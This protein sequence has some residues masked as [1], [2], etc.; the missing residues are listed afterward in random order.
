MSEKDNILRFEERAEAT[1]E[2]LF[3]HGLNGHHVKTWALDGKE[4]NYWPKWIEADV[5]DSLSLSFGYPAPLSIL[6]S[7]DMALPDRARNALQY[8]VNKRT[9]NRPVIVVVHSM[10]GLLIKQMLRVAADSNNARFKAWASNIAGIIFFATPH[11][12]SDW[13]SILANFQLASDT[14]AQMRRSSSWLEELHLWFVERKGYLAKAVFYETQDMLGVTKIVQTHSAIFDLPDG[15]VALDANHESITKF[16]GRDATGYAQVC[17]LV[18]AAARAP[19]LLQWPGQINRMRAL[20]TGLASE[21][22]LAGHVS[23]ETEARLSEG[24]FI[25]REVGVTAA[26]WILKATQAP[27]DTTRDADGAACLISGEAGYGKT[28][29]LWWLYRRFERDGSFLTIFLS[30]SWLIRTGSATTVTRDD[31]LAFCTYAVEIG[32]TP[33]ILIDTVDLLLRSDSDAA[34]VINALLEETCGAG[35]RVVMTTRPQ[36]AARLRATNYILTRS[37][38]DGYS[39]RERTAALGAYAARFYPSPKIA[40]ALPNF[41]NLQKELAYAG[42]LTEVCSSPLAMRMLFEIYAPETIPLQIDMFQLY[43]QYWSDRVESDRRSLDGQSGGNDLRAATQLIALLMLSEGQL[44]LE[45]TFLTEQLHAKNLRSVAIGE[46]VHRGILVR[47]GD[48]AYAFFHQTFFEHA[49]SRAMLDLYQAEGIRMLRERS[50]SRGGDLFIRPILEHALLLADRLGSAFRV[51]VSE[52]FHNLLNTKQLHNEMTAIGVFCR[53]RQQDMTRFSKMQNWIRSED[54]KPVHVAELMRHAVNLPQQRTGELFHLLPD[55]WMVAEGAL[56][57]RLHILG[58]LPRFAWRNASEVASF[59]ETHQVLNY[60]FHEDQIRSKAATLFMEAVANIWLNGGDDGQTAFEQLL[61]ALDRSMVRKNTARAE[62]IVQIV[63]IAGP[64]HIAV[65]LERS[66]PTFYRHWSTVMSASNLCDGYA[67]LIAA[68]WRTNALQ[69]RDI[70]GQVDLTQAHVGLVLLALIRWMEADGAAQQIVLYR[71]LMIE[72]S[73]WPSKLTQG[74]YPRAFYGEL[75]KRFQSIPELAEDITQFIAAIMN[76]DLAGWTPQRRAMRLG[77]AT[78]LVL[79]ADLGPAQVNR[80]FAILDNIS[81]DTW[82]SCKQL[83]PLI[84]RAHFADVA[85]A[86]QAYNRFKKAP[87][88]YPELEYHVFVGL[89]AEYEATGTLKDPELA[90]ILIGRMEDVAKLGRIAPGLAAWLPDSASIRG[91]LHETVDKLL[92]GRSHRGRAATVQR[93][94]RLIED[95]YYPM[96]SPAKA[97]ALLNAETRVLSR[98]HLARWVAT[99]VIVTAKDATMLATY[100]IDQLSVLLNESRNNLEF[101]KDAYLDALVSLVTKGFLAPD[102]RF[103]NVPLDERLLALTLAPPLNELHARKF[104]GII[105]RVAASDVSRAIYLFEQLLGAPAIDKFERTQK[106]DLSRHLWPA[107]RAV[108]EAGDLAQLRSMLN[109]GKSA[110]PYLGRSAFNAALDLRF[111]KLKQDLE[112]M[113]QD[114]DLAPELKRLITNFLHHNYRPLGSEAWEGLMTV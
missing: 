15:P 66:G 37:R 4:E 106:S 90:L 75:F 39:A 81:V 27:A 1:V 76:A 55:L 10:G 87:D 67:E 18:R 107:F 86:T 110:G 91:M 74:A 40:S 101:L 21:A 79:E 28:S 103:S 34:I 96:P 25:E 22:D 20:S 24:I 69:L 77:A 50:A 9:W 99:T 57:L 65:F 48:D 13:G 36:E 26:E 51:K 114:P 105:R 7:N 70:V 35:A 32:R 63:R 92:A 31:L 3:I 61:V 73:A 29:L 104:G 108:F 11:H 43:A 88:T 78:R 62:R 45:N 64:T 5:P 94:P 82:L 52:S 42:P 58:A 97:L 33:L 2:V 56:E 46:L 8:L 49:A 38:L 89:A 102:A 109:L 71:Q 30:A 12:G 112:Q 23:D 44:E 111:D 16:S 98:A 14:V 41:Q 85:S 84:V 83:F 93:L 17:A 6:G 60:A 100:C 47:A 54:C 113:R 59:L 68:H 72:T 19:H 80:L 53:W 95:G